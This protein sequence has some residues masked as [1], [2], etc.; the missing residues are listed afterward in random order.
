MRD[1]CNESFE[2]Q[3]RSNNVLVFIK[4]EGESDTQKGNQKGL[5]FDGTL[6]P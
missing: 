2:I 1:I 6:M 4:T 5:S 3:F